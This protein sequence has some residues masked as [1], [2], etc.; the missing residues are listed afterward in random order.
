MAVPTTG[1]Q[2]ASSSPP[3]GRP[4][5]AQAHRQAYRRRKTRAK[6][7]SE[8]LRQSEAAQVEALPVQHP[9]AAGIDI[10]SRSHWVCV[11]FTA[12]ADSALVCEFATHTDGLYQ[13]VAYLRE[14][15]VSTVALE[16][17]G[18]YR[19]PLLEI[20]QQEGFEVLLVDPAYT[21]QLRGRPKT[22]RKDAQWIYRLHSVGLLPAAFRPADLIVVLRSYV[23]QRGSIVHQAGQCIQRM[24]KALEQMN[25]KLTTVI[26]DITGQ[27]GRRILQ[28]ILR[29]TRDPE[30]L[31]QHRHPSCRHSVAEIA[32]ALRGN[33]RA[34]HLL[35]LRLAYE[36][37]TFLQGQLDQVD[38]AIETHLKKMGSPRDLPALPA[39]RCRSGRKANDPRFDVR[40]ALYR[41]IGMDLTELEGLSE[42]TVLSVVSEV[43]LD[44]RR[45]PTVKHFCSWLGLCPQWRKTGGK[46]KSSHTRAGPNRAATALRLAA[47]SLHRS[48]SALGAFL[49]RMKSRLGKAAGITATAHKLA[50][51]LYWSLSKGLAYAKQTQEH[52]EQEQK[53]RARQQ[54]HKQARRLGL[55]L[56]ERA[57][58]SAAAASEGSEAVGAAR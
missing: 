6:A 57:P 20:L 46:V 2:P 28:A 5:Q 3:S 58:A 16:A 7:K 34:E 25:L 37:W 36:A 8:A 55:E 4:A 35:A 40:A 54:L 51:L 10:G 21:R 56:I 41:I 44:M 47:G 45:F 14:H 42:A 38:A 22:D 24:Q 26:D 23:R 12:E 49:R 27:T 33:Y 13:I 31:A 48:R 39:K 29:G 19:I 30:K 17:T 53:Q 1:H 18:V 50:R 32:Q 43:G 52:Y 11:G 9:H 15:Q